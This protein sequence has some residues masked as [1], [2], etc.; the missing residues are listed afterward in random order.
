MPGSALASPVFRAYLFVLVG[1]LVV[2]GAAIALL[3]FG[4]HRNVDHAWKAYRG[5]L[6]M[7]PLVFTALFLGRTATIVFFTLI[8]IGAF[9]EFARATGL[10]RDWWLT[11]VVLLGIAAVGAVSLA[12]AADN[13]AHGWYGMLMALPLYVV[14]AIL[15]VP[16]IRHPAQGQ[17]Q[18]IA[19]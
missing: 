19:L 10:Y 11:G 13:N 12:D 16:I 18:S 9:S 17:L 2:A 7:I 4:F 6:I 1:L 14:A 15:M 8:A 3:R 5:W